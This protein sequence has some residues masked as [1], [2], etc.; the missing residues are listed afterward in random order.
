VSRDPAGGRHSARPL[1]VVVAVAGLVLT[2]ALAWATATVN[3]N[4]NHRLVQLEV[5]Q[6]AS[7]ISVSLT[8]VQ[9][10]LDDALQVE[11]DTKDTAAFRRFALGKVRPTGSFGSLSLWQTTPTGVRLLTVV[12]ATPELVTDLGAGK[13]LGHLRPSAE[14]A[15]AKTL[16]SP[17]HLGYAYMPPGD[18]TYIIYAENPLPTSHQVRVPKGSDFGDLNFA[19]YLGATQNSSAL[20]EAT[21]PTP[22]SGPRAVARSPFGNTYITLVGA[23]VSPLTGHLTQALPWVLL[24]GGIFIS[25]VSA[26]VLEYVLRRRHLAEA[27]AAENERLYLEQ[28]NIAR[29]LQHALLP[30]VPAFGALAVAARYIPG[31]AGVE[32]GGDWYDVIDLGA[33]RCIFVVGDVSGRG[34]PAATAMASLRYATRA[35]I[36]EGDGPAVVLAKLGQMLSFE[37]DNQFATV[38]VGELDLRQHRLT[39]ATAGHFPPLLIATGKSRFVDVEVAPP[40]GVDA[41]SRPTAVTT[42]VPPAGTLIA[43]TDGLVERRGEQLDVSLDRLRKLAE[44][45][46]GP[47]D[48]LVDRL[49][50]ALVPEGGQDDMVV[51]GLRWQR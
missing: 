51:L 24:G 13:L 8:S 17:P 11:L 3:G 4:N 31:V 39:L 12:G 6:A 44:R 46:H 9:D 21:V 20:I 19:L 1:T 15:V 37:R 47:V 16:G 26:V 49:V 23:P 29:T 22:L 7:V 40:V 34:L 45:Q 30:E 14:L 36:A 18:R 35:Y 38:L 42:T 32:V 41:N 50:A 25:L 27:L 33:D 2:A 48:G 5:R 43:F 28:R 10:Q